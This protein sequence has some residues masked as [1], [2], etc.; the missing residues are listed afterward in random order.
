[1]TG[2]WDGK[3]RHRTTEVSRAGDSWRPAAS[4]TSARYQHCGV[5]LEDNTVLITGGQEGQGK[6]GAAL[7]LVERYS[8]AGPLIQ[9]LPSLN[10]AE[11]SSGALQSSQTHMEDHYSLMP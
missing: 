6:Y 4:L 5:V 3:K 2:G 8:L 10:Q 7:S 1:M 11:W 9:N